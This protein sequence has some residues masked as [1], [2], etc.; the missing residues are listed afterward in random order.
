MS[1]SFID[2]LAGLGLVSAAMDLVAKATIVL[3][4]AWLVAALLPRSSAAVRHRLWSLAL[5]GIVILPF[6]C[7]SLPGWR[8]PILPVAVESAGGIVPADERVRTPEG[9]PSLDSASR[10][11]T[12][13]LTTWPGRR[14]GA[15]PSIP[16]RAES[17][18]I[19]L[20]LDRGRLGPRFPRGR[21]AGRR[22]DREERMVPWDFAARRRPRVAGDSR[23]T[24]TAARARSVGRAEDRR[25]PGDP[26]HLGR[27]AAGRALAR[28]VARVAGIDPSARPAP[29]ARARQAVRRAVPTGRPAGGRRLLVPSAGLVRPPSPPGRMRIRLRRLR[30]RGRRAAHRLCPRAGGD[31]PDP[32]LGRARGRGPDEP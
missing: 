5:C 10:N 2:S 23:W 27:L 17:G 31:G 9:G 19:D 14:H 4:L 12:H 6:L 32:R 16:A 29:R 26:G 15:K 28:V 21:F 18:P 7:W 25:Q 1:P 8:L 11:G 3:V 22:G 24:L 20:R 13:R 30:R